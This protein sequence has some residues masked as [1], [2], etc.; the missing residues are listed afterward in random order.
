MATCR[1]QVLRAAR[2]VMRQAGRETFTAAEVVGHLKAEGSSYSENTIRTHVN[3]R[4]CL[5]APAN[6]D[7]VYPDFRRVARGQYRL[8]SD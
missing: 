4:M 2:A 8:V 7:V 6:H 3:S 1:E 5:D